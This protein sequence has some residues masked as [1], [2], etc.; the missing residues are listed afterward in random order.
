MQ[1]YEQQEIPTDRF[2]HEDYN[3]PSHCIAMSYTISPDLD[4]ESFSVRDCSNGDRPRK[5][6]H[7]PM[8]PQAVSDCFAV[9][10]IGGA[11]TPTAIPFGNSGQG[12]LRA[13]CSALHF[14]PIKTVDWKIIFYEKPCNDMTVKIL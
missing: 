3:F 9:G 5:K 4:D 10:I 12:K 1:E 13:V 7:N 8:E 2:S 14:E 11:C 6:H